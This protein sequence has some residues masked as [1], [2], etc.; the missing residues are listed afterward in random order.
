M[1]VNPLRNIQLLL[2]SITSVKP[3][4]GELVTLSWR[5]S[6]GA[7]PY[8]VKQHLEFI[9][10]SLYESSGMSSRTEPLDLNRREYKFNINGPIDIRLIG[11][12]PKLILRETFVKATL[13]FTQLKEKRFPSQ[14]LLKLSRFVI[15][16]L[17]LLGL[18]ILVLTT[19]AR[20]LH[21]QNIIPIYSS[22]TSR[23]MVVHLPLKINPKILISLNILRYLTVN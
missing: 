10:P 6:A 8:L 11:R 4:I 19:M 12:L 9:T 18:L 23:E 22:K 13:L 1:V 3:I 20:F 5:Y 14:P 2:L 21:M 17:Q 7:E 15:G 16:I